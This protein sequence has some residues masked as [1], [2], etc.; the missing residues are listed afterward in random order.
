MLK[1]LAAWPS[2]IFSAYHLTAR[3]NNAEDSDLNSLSCK[4]LQP[5]K[6]PNVSSVTQ[7]PPSP[8]NQRMLIVVTASGIWQETAMT[9]SNND[10]GVTDCI[11]VLQVSE[12]CAREHMRTTKR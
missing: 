4:P 12:V 6:S 9:V 10:N 1:M 8:M 7:R 3:C 11:G 2:E 5:S